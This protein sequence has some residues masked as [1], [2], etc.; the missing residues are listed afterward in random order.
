MES[1]FK[2]GFLFAAGWFVSKFCI[3]FAV[4][5]V[6]KLLYNV[7]PRYANFIDEYERNKTR[8]RLNH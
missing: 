6:D 1:L 8:R 5:F 3:T 7:W 2:T 4:S